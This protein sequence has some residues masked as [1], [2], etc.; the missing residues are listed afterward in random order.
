M[1]THTLVSVWV[2]GA[3]D[4]GEAEPTDDQA[5]MFN[6]SKFYVID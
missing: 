2:N 5:F 1:L 6:P 3:D 4:W